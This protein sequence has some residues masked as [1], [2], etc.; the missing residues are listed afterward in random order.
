MQRSQ[1][2]KLFNNNFNNENS[3]YYFN[4]DIAE[5]NDIQAIQHSI[6][7]HF[8]VFL[9]QNHITN[10]NFVEKVK[11][12][13]NYDSDFEED[14][15]ENPNSA[16]CRY[17][18]KL[19]L[20]KLYDQYVIFSNFNLKPVSLYRLESKNNEGLY[21]TGFASTININSNQPSPHSDIILNQIFDDAVYS[22]DEEYKRKWYFA[23]KNVEETNQWANHNLK[24][25][26]EKY[27]LI[28]KKI[29]VPAE[30]VIHG[31][32]QSIFQKEHII[33]EEIIK[34]DNIVSNKN[35]KKI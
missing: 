32:Q 9:E 20:H 13:Y 19:N 22:K 6:D 3:F 5:Y 25:V 31:E 1:F 15:E 29:T 12:L 28:I 16:L 26:I 8:S 14:E 34:Y 11:I 21:S 2:L 30:F 18:C 33:S 10:I 17:N 23:F 4:I 35:K 27:N 7:K 24:Q